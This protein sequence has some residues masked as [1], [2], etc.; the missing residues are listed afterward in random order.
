MYLWRSPNQPGTLYVAQG[1]ETTE[2]LCRGLTEDGFIVKLVHTATNAPFELNGGRLCPTEGLIGWDPPDQ[3][4]SPAVNALAAALRPMQFR[5]KERLAHAIIP[6][7]GSQTVSIFGSRFSLDLSDFIQ[8]NVFAGSYERLETQIVRRLL[9]PGMTFLDVGANVG[10][11]SAMAAECV[12]P[13]GRVI[14]FEPAEY[15]FFRLRR[16]VSVNRLTWVKV[17]PCGLSDAPGQMT[18]YGGAE[19]DPLRNHTATMVPNENPHRRL[20]EIDTLDRFAERLEIRHIDLIKID[21]DGLEMQV[22][23][24]AEELIDDGRID[25]IL[26]ECNEYW[27][28][29]MNTSTAEITEHLRSKGFNGGSRIGR[30]DNYLFSLQ[31]AR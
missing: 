9:R 5:G 20:V 21:V 6:K 19:D 17:Y 29:R 13:E 23:R 22:L 10:Y 15:A 24:G 8:R 3:G 14:A 26:I 18:L 7:T 28:E 12:G 11:Y 31:A 30:S 1:F 27:L 2:A 4:V 16:M 25:H